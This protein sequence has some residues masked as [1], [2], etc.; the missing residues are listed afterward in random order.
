M[1]DVV[2]TMGVNVMSSDSDVPRFPKYSTF[3]CKGAPDAPSPVSVAG[4]FTP[5]DTLVVGSPEV[6]LT[7]IC[8]G[9]SVPKLSRGGFGTLP[10]DCA[11][12]PSRTSPESVRS[13]P[14]A[15]G[16]NA[17]VRVIISGKE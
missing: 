1:P 9:C 17:P 11:G 12:Q 3:N 10:S 6:W 5:S 15:S 16:R 2:E 8:T 13:T 7:L 4:R 14:W